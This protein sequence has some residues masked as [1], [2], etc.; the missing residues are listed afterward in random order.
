MIHTELDFQLRPPV[1]LRRLQ[2][3]FDLDI[4]VGVRP[5]YP[6]KVFL[7]EMPIRKPRG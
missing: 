6:R 5:P 3:A 1:L 4:K 2:G 7:R